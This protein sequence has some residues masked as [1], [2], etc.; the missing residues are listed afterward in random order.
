MSTETQ[1]PPPVETERPFAATEQQPVSPSKTS[2][3]VH[4][5]LLPLCLLAVGAGVVVALGTVEPDQRAGADLSLAGRMKA[6]PPVNVVTVRSLGASGATL[7]LEVD[8]T[9][10]PF[11]EAR[12]AAEVAGRVVFKA[13]DCEAG[14]FVKKG[15]LLMKLDATDYELEVQRLSRLQEQEYEAIA[16][17]DQEMINVRRLIEVAEEDVQL[18]KNEVDR[19]RSLPEGFSSRG[20]VDRARRTLLQAQQQLVSYENQM[21]L[22]RKRRGRLEASEQ[23]AATQRR[24]AEVNLARTEITAPIDG[25]IVRE[26]ADLNTF[27]SRG[28][29]L[30]TI[31][32]HIES[33]SRYESSDR[34]TVLGVGSTRPD[35]RQF[36]EGIRSARHAG[37]HRV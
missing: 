19:Q 23:L 6:L 16:E 9:V 32:G 3:L 1:N 35:A 28:S 29:P 22:L 31:E 11:R 10:V 14:N 12:V 21:D 8:G 33:R 36:A 5:V 17:V 26:D 30:V 25:V 24:A 7:Q 34:S 20:E 37:G 2:G 4:N 13:D 27:V 18:Q 15:Q